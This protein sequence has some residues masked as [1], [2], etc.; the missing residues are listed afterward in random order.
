MLKRR[1]RERDL[2]M[3]KLSETSSVADLEDGERDQEPRAGG[4]VETQ[5]TQGHEFSS[6][7]SFLGNTALQT[8]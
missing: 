4:S 3:G 1:L 6:R 5:E 7:A 2:R 8:L